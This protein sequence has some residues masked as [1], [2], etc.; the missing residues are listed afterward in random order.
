MTIF[1][2]RGGTPGWVSRLLGPGEPEVTCEECFDSL[3]GY[4]DL[5]LE[6]AGAERRFPGMRAHLQGCG[7]CRE[8]HD[9]LLEF[10]AGH[11]R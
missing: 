6:G 2:R 3:D 5:E 10:A 9:L 4:V 7:A 11:R 8:E 1:G